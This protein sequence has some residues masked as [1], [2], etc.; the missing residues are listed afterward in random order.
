MDLQLFGNKKSTS[1]NVT[2][3]ASKAELPIKSGK[4]TVKN[5]KGEDVKIPDG[6]IISPRDPD[7]LAKPITEAGPYTSA[8]RD[9]FL[10]GN[11]AGTKLYPFEYLC[12]NI[13]CVYKYLRN[14]CLYID[15]QIRM[16]ERS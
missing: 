2:K 1:P 7:F 4:N 12:V 9:A 5:W 8:Q 10:A 15:R 16:D 13:I 11:S 6:H 3:G 14:I